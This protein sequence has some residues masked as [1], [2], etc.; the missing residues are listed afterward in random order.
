VDVFRGAIGGP[1]AEVVKTVTFSG[2]TGNGVIPDVTIDT[3]RQFIFFRV[4]QKS[5]AGE[6]L[7]WTS[8][9]WWERGT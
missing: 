6:D 3:D 2:N 5:A 8:P 7:S 4:R 9:V 1:L